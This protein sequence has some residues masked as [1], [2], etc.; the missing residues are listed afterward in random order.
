MKILQYG[1]KLIS[2]AFYSISECL[3]NLYLKFLLVVNNVQFGRGVRTIGAV[4]SFSINKKAGCVI[5]G[6]NVVFNNCANTAYNLKCYIRVTSGAQL[7]IGNN[8]GMNVTMIRK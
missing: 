2:F 8:S 3:N 7:S 6:S 1:Y 5:F 4:P